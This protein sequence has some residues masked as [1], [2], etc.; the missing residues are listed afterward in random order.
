[1]TSEKRTM[2]G[3]E[4]VEALLPYVELKENMKYLEI[5][6]GNGH[7]AKHIAKKYN[8]NAIGTDIDPDMIYL[9]KK[10]NANIFNLQFKEMDATKLSFED[11]EFDIVLSFEIMHHIHNWKDAINEISRVIKPKG[12]YIFEDIAF[13]KTSARFLRK[14]TK[15]LGVYTLEEIT[16]HIQ[17]NQFKII[18]EGQTK[19]GLVLYHRKVLQKL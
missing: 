18:H 3:I 17:S 19:E 7:V 13:S 15:N 2:Q 12:Y 1:M 4:H 10:E 5:G 8:L 16:N 6:C 14:I 11:K 9:A